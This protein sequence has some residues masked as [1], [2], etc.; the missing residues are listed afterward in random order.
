MFMNVGMDAMVE[1]KTFD[2]GYRKSQLRTGICIMKHGH[3]WM[4][5]LQAKK[6]NLYVQW[7]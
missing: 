6:G 7:R 2:R 3:H 5:I 1:I 4:A